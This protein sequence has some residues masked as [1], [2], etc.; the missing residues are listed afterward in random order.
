[1]GFNVWQLPPGALWQLDHLAHSPGFTGTAYSGNHPYGGVWAPLAERA[2]PHPWSPSPW[3]VTAAQRTPGPCPTKARRCHDSPYGPSPFCLWSRTVR[4][5]VPSAQTARPSSALAATALSP[6]GG[7]SLSSPHRPRV[8]AA[9][10]Q[11][12]LPLHGVG[13]CRDGRVCVSS[14]T[15]GPHLLIAPNLLC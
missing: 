10:A 14:T 6:L 2:L 11:A 9:V 13:I 8:H 3:A 12:P 5:S 4:S 7:G 1:M 15:D